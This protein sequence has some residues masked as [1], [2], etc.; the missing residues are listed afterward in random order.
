MNIL[1]W[2]FLI[3]VNGDLAQGSAAAITIDFSL[4]LTDET[5]GLQ[6]YVVESFVGLGAVGGLGGDRVSPVRSTAVL[7]GDP[8]GSP[9]SARTQWNLSAIAIDPRVLIVLFNA[10]SFLVKDIA[11]VTVEAQGAGPSAPF[12]IEDLPPPWPHVP[13]Q[14]DDDRTGPIVELHI[15]F[16]APLTGMAVEIV[17]EALQSWLDCGSVQGYRDW[18]EDPDK[19]FLA[20][21]DDPA[22]KF[23]G[24]EVSA[25]LEDSGVL[26]GCYDILTNVL[27]KLNDSVPIV[28]VEL[29]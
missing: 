25:T 8:I 24:D 10:L 3:S 21:T 4:P 14:E 20:P 26:E 13:F 11:R 15:D 1:G 16:A 17:E 2:P 22:F 19:S 28:S 27:I 23:E 9:G 5:F 7:S 6:S 18:S 29:M 12:S